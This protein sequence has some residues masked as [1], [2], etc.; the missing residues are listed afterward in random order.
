M[1][2]ANQYIKIHETKKQRFW[3]D[4]NFVNFLINKT[5][6]PLSGMHWHE[7]ILCQEDWTSHKF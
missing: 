6:I 4:D 5:V 1:A 2:S 3:V 7:D